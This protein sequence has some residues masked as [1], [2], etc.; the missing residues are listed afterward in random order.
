MIP[1]VY[2]PEARDDVADAFAWY[3]SRQPSLGNRFLERLKECESRIEA[4]PT[5]PAM[6]DPGVR[7]VPLKRTRTVCTIRLMMI[8]S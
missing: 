3:E 8:R 1:V 5:L 6:M 4:Y 7:A 2:L